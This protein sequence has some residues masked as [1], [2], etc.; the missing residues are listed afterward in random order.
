MKDVYVRVHSLSC[1]S[2]FISKS[3]VEQCWTVTLHHILKTKKAEEAIS[4]YF[5]GAI[6]PQENEEFQNTL[7]PFIVCSFQI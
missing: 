1:I 2:H 7:L 3:C 5:A 4:G 6:L